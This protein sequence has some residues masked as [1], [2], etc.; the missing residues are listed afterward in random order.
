MGQKS[1]EFEK[2]YGQQL[3]KFVEV[4]YFCLVIKP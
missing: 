2:R 3:F 1:N 4:V